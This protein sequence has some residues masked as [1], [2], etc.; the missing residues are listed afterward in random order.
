MEKI[1]EEL[2][3]FATSVAMQLACGLSVEEIEQLRNLVNQI[4]CSLSTL[5]GC[6]R[7]SFSK[8]Q[9]K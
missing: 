7:N 5:I 3:L 8:K 4:S 1:D 9:K 2:V 6:R